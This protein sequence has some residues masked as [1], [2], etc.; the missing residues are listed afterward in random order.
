MKTYRTGELAEMAG[1]HRC[2]VWFD[3]RKGKLKTVNGV[4]DV[5][6]RI[7]HEEAMRWL[8]SRKK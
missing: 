8:E 7:S 4:G 3:I 1:V 2:T 5:W 6:H